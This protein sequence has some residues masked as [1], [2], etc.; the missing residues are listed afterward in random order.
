MYG[1]C[2]CN[3]YNKGLDAFINFLKK[4]ML[5]NVRE[6]LC[7]PCKYCKNAKKYHTNDVLRS[8][9]IKYG[10]MGRKDLMKQR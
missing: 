7:C 5:D 10:F 3:E 2:L 1:L 8:H 6:D 4:D 9:L